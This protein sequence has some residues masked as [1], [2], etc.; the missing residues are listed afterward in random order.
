[1]NLQELIQEFEARGITLTLCGQ[2]L[3]TSPETLPNG[4]MTTI[5]AHKPA[6]IRHLQVQ[7]P[8]TP[9]PNRDT[10]PGTLLDDHRAL[11]VEAL[12]AKGETVAVAESE[13][14]P[15]TLE[16]FHA[17]D[18][19]PKVQ[20]GE[21]LLVAIDGQPARDPTILTA[22]QAVKGE[23]QA[24]LE[25]RYQA[26]TAW[27]EN[28]LAEHGRAWLTTAD[29]ATWETETSVGISDPLELAAEV[30][31]CEAGDLY[32]RVRTEGGKRHAPPGADHLEPLGSITFGY[33]I[34][35]TPTIDMVLAGNKT[36]TRR[37]TKDS[38]WTVGG[39]YDVVPNKRAPPVALIKLL[40]LRQERVGDI[41]DVDAQAEGVKD[42]ATFKA[43]WAKF[44]RGWDPEKPVWV[45]EFK[46]LQVME[47]EAAA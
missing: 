31:R 2:D 7:P 24:G 36:Q 19:Y 47:S 4:I 26:L 42:A 29:D 20:D 3:S 18:H 23:I 16:D 13:Q 39:V 1:M 35:K 30:L 46:L 9:S 8:A 43:E 25:A 6:L 32:A 22:W 37:P 38:A 10:P 44:K 45:L 14:A 15:C 5:Q 12:V 17:H 41:T 28:L 27:A 11:A 40:D 21:L 34:G 33:R